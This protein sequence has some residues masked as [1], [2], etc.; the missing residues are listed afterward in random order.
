MSPCSPKFSP[1]SVVMMKIYERVLSR[2]VDR[3]WRDLDKAVTVPKP[4]K[5]WI[6]IRHGVL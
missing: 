6:A 3:G 4:E 1:W 2:L 5:I